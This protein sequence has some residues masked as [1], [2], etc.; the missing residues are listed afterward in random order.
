[1]D[2]KRDPKSEVYHFL[3]GD[4]GMANYKDK[5]IKSLEPEAVKEVG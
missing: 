5:V 2:A 3:L 1:M 4:P